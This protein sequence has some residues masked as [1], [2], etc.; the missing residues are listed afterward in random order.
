MARLIR[1]PSMENLVLYDLD[2]L[3]MIPSANFKS[4]SFRR[5]SINPKYERYQ[6]LCN[7][8]RSK[9]DPI[10]A[11]T[12]MFTTIPQSR[13][14][15]HQQLIESSIRLENLRILSQRSSKVDEEKE[16]DENKEQTN[17]DE[18]QLNN[19]PS[20]DN[21]IIMNNDCKEIIEKVFN[22]N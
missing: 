1:R 19:D 18:T 5:P 16:N 12:P 9:I 15:I 11:A 4:Y 21:E 22:R 3:K 2:K 13:E 17:D 10:Y 14:E 7:A 20:I 6:F 8:Q